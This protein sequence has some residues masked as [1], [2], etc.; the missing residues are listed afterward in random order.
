M[1]GIITTKDYLVHSYEVDNFYNL[2]PEV[3]LRYLQDIAMEQSER[4]GVGLEY[5]KEHRLNWIITRYHVKVH[6]YPK[7]NDKISVTTNAVGFNKVFAYRDFNISNNSGEILITANSQWLLIDG[8]TQRM[9]K[10]GDQ[11][12]QA[13]GIDK[14][15]KI[16]VPFNKLVTPQK[17]LIIR[18]FKSGRSDIDFN[19]HVNNTRYIAWTLDATPEETL[20]DYTLCEFDIVF[21][22]EVL[23]NNEISVT[24]DI[25]KLDER[26][27]GYHEIKNDQNEVV[28]CINTIWDTK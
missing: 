19:G 26:L 12:Y 23:L 9:L 24:T 20:R 10:I 16:V 21:K 3:L 28:C 7:Y 15:K 22:K 2:L 11:F 1:S 5:I 6:S 18:S 27:A 4:I 14:N 8:D 13:Y 25:V 17:S